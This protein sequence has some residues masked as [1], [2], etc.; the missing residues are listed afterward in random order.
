VTTASL[1]DTIHGALILA[2][3]TKGSNLPYRR[4][5]QELG[6]RVTMSEMTVA[7]RLK[8]KRNSEFALIRKAAGERCFGVQLA[9]NNPEEMAWAAALVESRGADLVDVNLGC[10]IDYFT[11]KGLG[12][13][14]AREP[15][16]VGRI[17]AAMKQA[18]RVPVTVKIRLGWND[19]HRNYLDVAR[20]AVDAGADAIT[21]HGRTRAARYTTSADWTAIGEAAAGRHDRGALIKPWLFREAVEGDLDLTAE[22]RLEIDRRYVALAK[23]HWGA[24]EHG[25]SRIR[26]F[27][28]WHL[29]F[30]CRY[31]PRRADGSYPAM[32][33]R[34]SW[35]PRTPLEALLARS[36]AP[37]H[38]YLADRLL[39]DEPVDPAH[40]PAAAAAPEI[41]DDR[42]EAG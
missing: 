17:V 9:G 6:A 41:D 16:R 31:A 28:L 22:E 26:V 10:P 13:A 32:Q 33:V 42:A 3:M 27:L 2:P 39:A 34:E 23:E 37:A 30:W 8:Q 36:D 4:L 35:T 1:R 12:A 5:C 21:V 40:A 15:R 29:G 24:D 20:A 7:R 38:E 14:L 19:E 18:V 11:S 25:V